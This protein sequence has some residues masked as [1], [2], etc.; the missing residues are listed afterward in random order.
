MS[1]PVVQVQPQVFVV[2]SGGLHQVV[3]GQA[4]FFGMMIYPLAQLS[5]A[6]GLVVE[7]ACSANLDTLMGV[8]GT[9]ADV[10]F[11]RSGL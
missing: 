6:R 2:D 4:V 8:N 9:Q 10:E 1:L 7:L 5:K 3:D 11:V